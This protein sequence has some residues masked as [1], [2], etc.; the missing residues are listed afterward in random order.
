MFISNVIESAVL[1]EI[2]EMS[3]YAAAPLARNGDGSVCELNDDL[4][5]EELRCAFLILPA[6]VSVPPGRKMYTSSNIVVPL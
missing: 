3:K 1:A 4:F 6:V 5:T 2:F